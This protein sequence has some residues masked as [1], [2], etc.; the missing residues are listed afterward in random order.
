MMLV[1]GVLPIL[2]AGGFALYSV[3][4]SHIKSV[5][6]IEKNLLNQKAEEVDSFIKGN[7]E[8]INLYVALGDLDAEFSPAAQKTYLTNIMAV[9]PAIE[10]IYFFHPY[11]G[12]ITA[13]VARDFEPSTQALA[14]S[15]AELPDFRFLRNSFDES[16][17]DTD[18][19][20]V[21]PVNITPRG[22]EIEV[23]ATVKN[24]TSSIISFVGARISLSELQNIVEA[25]VLGETGYVY[26]T[27]SAGR[28]IAASSE[29]TTGATGVD[30]VGL[31]HKI[32]SPQMTLVAEWP[33]SEAYAVLANLRAQVVGFSFLALLA[34]V[35]L[36]IF[37]A[38][39]IVRPIRALEEGTKFVAKGKFDEPVSVKTGDEL[40]ELAAAFNKMTEGLKELEKL[41]DEFVFIAAHEL[42]TPVAAI[43]G[44]LSLV[45]DGLAGKV[46]DEA[47]Q[48][49]D[50]VIAANT[51]LVK[52]VE[53]LLEVARAE[54]GRIKIDVAPTDVVPVVR[55]TL[56]ELKPLSDEKN[57]TLVY[58]PAGGIPRV[59]ADAARVR[60]VLVNLIGNSIKYTLG[61][62][63]VT[64]SHEVR[65][66]ELVTNIKDTGI[67]IS[68]EAQAKLF[69][70][71]YRVQT[72]QTAKITGT[73]LGL[74]IVKQII[75]KMG[76]KIWFESQE[77]KGSTFSFSLKIV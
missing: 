47:K 22:P 10:D 46:D 73:G 70:K 49:I 13:R 44:Y 28:V 63:T 75:E 69:E 64:I 57:I 8:S 65:A 48:F 74:F 42:K 38:N 58:Q 59:L 4:N 2:A 12:E 15:R 7:L 68:K 71:F 9:S 52:L 40:E 5:N 55:E 62:G 30:V 36:S 50:K 18:V 43:K 67:G 39:K 45:R 1:V 72:P 34:V 14:E 26:L 37:L 20:Y 60:E 51:R 24:F 29:K 23:A 11:T 33:V 53:D 32:D 16:V 77:G 31:V 56:S 27:D 76:G 25:S 54:A 61:G 6:D 66:G 21:G 35:I 3:T 17:K 19:F 41:K